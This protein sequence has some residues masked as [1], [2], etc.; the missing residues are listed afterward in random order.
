LLVAALPLAGC[1]VHPVERRG[2]T[3][4][5]RDAQVLSTLR[6]EGRNGDWLVARGYHVTDNM[7]ATLTNM[8][9]SHAAVLDRDADRVIEAESAGVHATPLAQFV[10][11]SQRVMLIRPVWAHGDAS[12]A[13]AAKAR[14]LLGRPYDFAGLVGLSIP[15][16]YYCSELAVEIY[17]PW[18]REGDIIP[19]PVAPGQLHYW[20]KVVYD[21][22][23]R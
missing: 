16:E 18:V 20:G 10:A 3:D 13:A 2:D 21:T 15:N 23:A 12:E 4:A 19:R 6:T 7:V 17:R 14:T 1:A 8:P 11:K 9:F 22:G 5:D